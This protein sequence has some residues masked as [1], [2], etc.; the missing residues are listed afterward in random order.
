MYK[1]EEVGSYAR[2]QHKRRPSHTAN[3]KRLAL[4]AVALVCLLACVGLAMQQQPKAAPSGIAIQASGDEAGGMPSQTQAVPS[5]PEDAWRLLLVNAQN[6][7]PDNHS[8]SLTQLANGHAVDERCYA[9]LQ[10]MMDDCRAAGNSPIICSSY[11][12]SR[13]QAR[14]FQ[15]LV[16]KYTARGF[17]EVDARAVA[18][19]AVAVPGTSEHQLGLA[20]DIVDLYNQ[21][22][23]ESQE[24]TAVQAWLMKNSWKYGFILRYPSDKG[25]LTGI[26]YEPWHYRYVGQETAKLM[27]E[28]EL[29]L[30]E[31]LAQV[32]TMA[33]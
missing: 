2:P 14:L 9:D 3:L 23:N 17:S 27:Y 4:G 11:R 31:Y 21:N 7:M 28:Q 6:P 30:E 15:N 5:A 18:G 1:S 20:V 26:Q 13:T 12:D 19:R 32:K 8:V 33:N 16:N 22:L 25:D 24:D 10:I 29:C